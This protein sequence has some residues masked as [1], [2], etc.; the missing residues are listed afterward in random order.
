MGLARTLTLTDRIEASAGTVVVGRVRNEKSSYNQLEDTH[1]RMSVVQAGDL[2]AGALGHRN[3]LHGY[4]GVLPDAVAPGDVLNI[5][6]LGG[7]V[8]HCVSHNRDVGPPFEL[9]V[10]GQVLAFPE[11]ESRVGRPANITMKALPASDANPA[12]PVIYIAGTCMNAGKTAAACAIV[13]R[14]SQAGFRVGGAKLTGVS[15]V[16]DILGMRDYGA[17]WSYDFTD[18]GV[19]ATTDADAPA[20]ARAIFAKLAQ[21]GANVVVAETGDGIMGEYGVQAI[22]ADPGLMRACRGF[23]LCANDP[24]GVAGAVPHLRERYGIETAVLAGPATD[25]RVGCRFIEREFGIPALNALTRPEALG[26]LVL[27][28]LRT[29]VSA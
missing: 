12:S 14:L 21:H 9:E 23:V 16:R 28:L 6:N 3:A 7:V 25:N 5:L 1:G 20:A 10:L 24:V 29:E 19:V 13:R 17:V 26:E 4:E 18:A 11:F 2:I 22:L 8:G 15:L 27:E